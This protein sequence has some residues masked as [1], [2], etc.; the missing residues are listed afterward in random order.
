MDESEQ[1]KSSYTILRK[2]GFTQG[3]LLKGI[4]V[5]QLFNFGIS[6]VAGLLHSYFAIKSGWFFLRR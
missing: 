4:P 6:L 2:L 1:E 3:D 5:K